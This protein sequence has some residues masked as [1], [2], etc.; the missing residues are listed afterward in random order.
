MS[1]RIQAAKIAAAFV[2]AQLLCVGCAIA[3]EG[4]KLIWGNIHLVNGGNYYEFDA[5]LSRTRAQAR[6][7]PLGE[8]SSL[9]IPLAYSSDDVARLAQV[10]ARTVVQFDELVRR[11]AREAHEGI[12]VSLAEDFKSG[13]ER[14]YV[15]RRLNDSEQRTGLAYVSREQLETLSRKKMT[16]AD[17]LKLVR[18]L[19]FLAYG[20]YTIV[21]RGT[22][23]VVL[24]LEDLITSRVRTFSAEGRTG[25]V[26]GMLAT[27][28]VDF[29]QGVAYPNWEN[30]QPRL[31]W[32]APAFPQTKVSAQVAARYCEGQKA[33]LPYTAELLQAAMAGNY[34]NGGIGPLIGNSTYIVADRNLHDQQYYYTTGEDAQTQ[35]GGP[36]HTNAGH[37]SIVGYYWCVRGEPSNDTLFDQALYRLIRQNQQYRRLQVVFALEYVLAKRNDLGVDALRSATGGGSRDESF[38]SVENAVQFLAQN[39]V[40]L[41]LPR[42]E[43]DVS[44][45]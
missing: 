28:V 31:T 39:G 32:I 19:R 22:V 44:R 23:R 4:R 18:E 16:P 29:L 40:F 42:N 8:L 45:N 41:Q 1:I 13:I 26:G 11:H 33:R 3:E 12:P 6:A 15:D 34:R 43:Y 5:E 35:T 14:I 10:I 37:G 21:D 30:P 36:V 27:K 17:A 25:E 20:S 2:I 38:G 24:N 7:E 9:L